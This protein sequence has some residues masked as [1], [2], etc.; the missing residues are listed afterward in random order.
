LVL[1]RGATLELTLWGSGSCPTLP[2]A[3]TVRGP[4]TVEIT[5]NGYYEDNRACTADMV[6]C[7]LSPDGAI[8]AR[9]GQ[10]LP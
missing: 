4:A 3:L 8:L 6:I 5:V 10:Q 7:N 9:T 1:W 2:V